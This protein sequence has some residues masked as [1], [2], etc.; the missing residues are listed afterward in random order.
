M[1]FL[2]IRVPEEIANVL[3]R[4]DVSGTKEPRD[5][6]HVTM[7]L[8]DNDDVDALMLAIRTTMEVTRGCRPVQ[9]TTSLVTSFPSDQDIPVIA[10]V[11][12]PALHE[13]QE[14]IKQEWAAKGVEF[15]N[16]FHE[17]NPHCTLAYSP[18]GSQVTDQ[19]FDA[20]TWTATHLEM[21]CGRHDD[22]GMNVLFPLHETENVE[23]SLKLIEA[24]F[25]LAAVSDG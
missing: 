13:L 17:Y 19:T 21:W 1:A 18:A 7:L 22:S 14:R 2:G 15:S 3:S 12:S 25:R 11:E 4:L 16:K 6:M 20:I 5:E 9:L 10:K 8:T 23:A 24:A